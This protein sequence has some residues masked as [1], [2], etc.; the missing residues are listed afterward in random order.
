MQNDCERYGIVSSKYVEARDTEK[1]KQ[2]DRSYEK[3]FSGV[4]AVTWLRCF[5]IF[6]ILSSP[7]RLHLTFFNEPSN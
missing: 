6:P 5:G 7:F 2:C 3:V 1:G 4:V